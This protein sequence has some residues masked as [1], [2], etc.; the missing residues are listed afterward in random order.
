[1]T[2][3]DPIKSL[4]LLVESR[5]KAQKPYR[6]Y[7]NYGDAIM[8]DDDA[9]FY[10]TAYKFVDEA[11]RLLAIIRRQREALE[12]YANVQIYYEVPDHCGE[13]AR[14]ALNDEGDL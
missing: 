7:N 10:D 6:V 4:E 13:L 5:G 8:E 11:P 9:I 14:N 12:F 2:H 1:M 3:P